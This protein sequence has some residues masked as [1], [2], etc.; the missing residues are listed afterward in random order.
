MLKEAIVLGGEE[1]LPDQ[2]WNLVVGDRD[3]PLLADLGD[4][5]AA[6]GVNAQGNLQ[7]RVAHR[8]DAGQRGLEVDIGS[9]NAHGRDQRDADHGCAA[10]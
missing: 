6:A 7:F 9:G 8:L 2:Q 3:P 4:Q 5:L 1:G 10:Q